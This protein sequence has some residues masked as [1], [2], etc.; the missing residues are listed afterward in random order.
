M[1]PSHIQRLITEGRPEITNV[2][3][4]SIIIPIASDSDDDF[5]TYYSTGNIWAHTTDF[6]YVRVHHKTNDSY[7]LGQFR[8]QL[9][10]P[11]G[12]TIQYASITFW[13]HQVQTIEDATIKRINETN[14]GSLESDIIVP[15]V[16]EDNQAVHDF[17]PLLFSY[18]TTV[19]TEMVNDQV[20]LLDWKSGFYFG[21]QVNMTTFVE[22]AENYFTDFQLNDGHEAFMN[23]TYTENVGWLDGWTRR[24]PLIVPSDLISIPN[25][26]SLEV[27]D[28]YGV[29]SEKRV[30]INDKSSLNFNEI[31]FTSNDGRTLINS[32]IKEIIEEQ[33]TIFFTNYSLQFAN[34]PKNYPA[35][36]YFNNKTYVVFQGNLDLSNPTY[37]PYIVYYDHI[38]QSWSQIYNVAENPKEDDDHGSPALW[39]D[40][41]GFIHVTYGAHGS[42][43][44]HAKSD[45]SEN[46]S[47]FTVQPDISAQYVTYPVISYDS[48]NDVV[49]IY[50]RG[51]VNEGSQIGYIGYSKSND[52]GLTWTTNE[53]LIAFDY[54]PIPWGGGGIDPYNP[55]KLHISWVGRTYLGGPDENVYYAYLNVSTGLLYNAS[56]VSLGTQIDVGES[57]E[58]TL[59]W[60][61]SDCYVGGLIVHVDLNTNP[62]LIFTSLNDT[63]HSYATT[64]FTYWT[65]AEWSTV[66]NITAIP[67]VLMSTDFIVNS[68]NNITAYLNQGWSLGRFSWDGIDWRFEE[69]IYTTTELH[70]FS[71]VPKNYHTD[72]QVTFTEWK[73]NTGNPPPNVRAYAWGSK[74]LLQGSISKHAKFSVEFPGDVSES[75]QVIY[76]Y[77]SPERDSP[78][79]DTV[80]NTTSV[81]VTTTNPISTENPSSQSTSNSET[82][83][84]QYITTKNTYSDLLWISVIISNNILLF[85]FYQFK[86]HR[87]VLFVQ[88][89]SESP[90]LETLFKKS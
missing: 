59:V 76:L 50:Y 5:W 87:N 81:Q 52:N 71:M 11:R 88:K 51:L 34:Y 57:A 82:T 31:Q 22:G 56:G 30:F 67:R 9:D 86:K 89:K 4:M 44:K 84:I 46:I 48:I 14:V 43:L 12:V 1:S 75:N 83:Q 74:G 41:A 16:V 65:G 78:T 38:T 72:L 64:M 17:S 28:G 8:F 21:L 13:S 39:I 37:H 42:K 68:P 70:S 33:N 23:I 36:W 2:D 54:A 26:F 7:R 10:I 60:D 47:S 45:R 32:S 20:N 69:W 25:T 80:S 79:I 19:I 15:T 85:G 77:Y 6:G 3:P 27:Y 90:N 18:T 53:Q 55:S 49:H 66:Q 58:S 40:N 29:N 24:E 62:Y 61:S 63:S 35:G 73:W